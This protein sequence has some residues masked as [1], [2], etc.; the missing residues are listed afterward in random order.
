MEDKTDPDYVNSVLNKY[1]FMMNGKMQN[2]AW[3]EN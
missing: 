1:E 3:Y 2:G